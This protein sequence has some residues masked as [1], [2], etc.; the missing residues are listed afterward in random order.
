MVVNDFSIEVAHLS[1]ERRELLQRLLRQEGAGSAP[2]VLRR[3]GG[4]DAPLSFAQERL[5][6]L[7]QL[8]PGNPAYNIAAAVRFSGALDPVAL[9][10]ALGT[11]VYRH[12][13]LRTTFESRAGQPVQVVAP[14]LLL[15]V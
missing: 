12:D 6:F 7:D 3:F 8:G 13:V 2:K 14:T 9:E 10:Q 11:L 4:R 5:W 1:A 15:T